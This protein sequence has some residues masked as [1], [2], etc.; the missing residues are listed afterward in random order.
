MSI[1][2]AQNHFAAIDKCEKLATGFTEPMAGP[3]FPKEDAAAP[4][5]DKKS[6][7]KNVKM[8]EAIIKMSM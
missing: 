7:P 3:I 8:T 6:K 4:K 1:K 2:R 5:A